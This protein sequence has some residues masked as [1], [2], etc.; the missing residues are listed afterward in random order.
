[1]KLDR[2]IKELLIP[3]KITAFYIRWPIVT[4]YELTKKKMLP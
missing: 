2:K 4:Y 3:G 1:M